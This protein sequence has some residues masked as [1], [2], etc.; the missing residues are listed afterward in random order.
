MYFNEIL[1]IFKSGNNMNKYDR[2][3]YFFLKRNNSF[4]QAQYVFKK[5]LIL[6]TSYSDSLISQL[7]D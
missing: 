1:I 4:I 2:Q 5:Y 6:I 7:F 3:L